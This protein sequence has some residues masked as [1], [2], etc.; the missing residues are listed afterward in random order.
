MILEV[1]L[2][3]MLVV[4]EV[5][6]V[7]LEVTGSPV[8]AY[9]SLVAC[10]GRMDDFLRSTPLEATSPKPTK[11][12]ETTPKP[13]QTSKKMIDSILQEMVSVALQESS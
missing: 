5:A 12:S 13:A 6:L 7:V 1:M 9:H 2:E 11:A 10:T 4:L 8:T 3:V